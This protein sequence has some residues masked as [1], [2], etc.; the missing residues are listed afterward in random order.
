MSDFIKINLKNGECELVVRK[1]DVVLRNA[2]SDV[3]TSDRI[4]ERRFFFMHR[5]LLTLEYCVWSEITR[6]EYD[7]LCKELG[8]E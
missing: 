2:E 1:I 8:V 3:L 5:A 7:R 4:D 6:E